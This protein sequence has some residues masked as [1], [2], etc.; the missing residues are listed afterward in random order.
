MVRHR[1]AAAVLLAFALAL[2]DAES[3][4]RGV[5]GFSIKN[6]RH[7]AENR[8]GNKYYS[9]KTF[10]KMGVP[11]ILYSTVAK[12]TTKARRLKPNKI[13][14]FPAASTNEQAMP[15]PKKVAV[16]TGSNTG[17]GFQTAKK[18]A[19]EYNFQVIIA[20]RSK[21]RGE[22]ACQ[23]INDAIEQ[24]AGNQTTI[25]SG[26]VVFLAPLDLSDLDCVR[27][28]CQ[29]VN[30]KYDTI[31]VLINNAGKNSGGPPLPDQGLDD[32]FTTNFLGHF[33]LT[34][35]LLPKCKRIVNLSSVMHHFPFYS[36]D[37][38]LTDI[39]SVDFW[40]NAAVDDNY[41]DDKRTAVIESDVDGERE[42][43]RKPYAPSKLAALLFSIELNRRC[44]DENGF[45]ALAVN[46]GSV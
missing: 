21:K 13:V 14:E 46:P 18:L 19:I 31:D 29:V 20:C 8:Q 43:V 22:A 6:D 37:D 33:L 15:L 3:G 40:R 42:T 7:P 34:N 12:V 10:K 17:V 4:G 28:F 36:K 44:Q 24:Q 38:P 2:M 39:T 9:Y 11:A 41:V 35:L 5:Y 26:K 16:V 23:A 27:E 32:I 45:R 1:L 30:E 25:S